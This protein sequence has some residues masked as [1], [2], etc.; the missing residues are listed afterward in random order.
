M[1]FP[2]NYTYK[3][4]H[5][6]ATISRIDRRASARKT[7]ACEAGVPYSTDDQVGR[8][9]SICFNRANDLLDLGGCQEGGR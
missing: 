3:V 8:T 6:I 5:G 2:N 9:A 4:A 7:Y 1:S